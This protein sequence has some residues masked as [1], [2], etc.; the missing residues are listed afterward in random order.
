MTV[1]VYT[2]V[3]TA[4]LM[5]VAEDCHEVMVYDRKF[6]LPKKY[7]WAFIDDSGY[8]GVTEEKP[9]T[10][11]SPSSPPK[12]CLSTQQTEFIGKV[13]YLPKNPAD[14]INELEE[15]VKQPQRIVQL[16]SHADDLYGLCETGDVYYENTQGKWQL[17]SLSNPQS[18]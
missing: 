4:S 6:T 17:S 1:R 16:L 15:I 7:K 2:W 3:S 14:T 8:V 12:L 18:D 10:E 9:R 5:S 13:N 11:L